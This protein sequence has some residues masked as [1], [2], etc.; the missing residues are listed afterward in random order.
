MPTIQFTHVYIFNFF[1]FFH[2]ILGTVHL[3]L[4]SEYLSCSIC[5]VFP[6]YLPYLS[7]CMTGLK[8]EVVHSPLPHTPFLCPSTLSQF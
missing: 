7:S 2:P 5:S 8:L 4:F 1:I 3:F 6:S